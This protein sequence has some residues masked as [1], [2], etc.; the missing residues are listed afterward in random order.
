[1]QWGLTDVSDLDELLAAPVSEDA[2]LHSEPPDEE[3][4]LAYRIYERM[5]REWEAKERFNTLSES[6]Y[7]N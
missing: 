7:V 5:D 3:R 4:D 2:A 1:V 6:R